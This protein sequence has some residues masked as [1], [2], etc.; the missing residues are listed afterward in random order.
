[1]IE[2]RKEILLHRIMCMSGGFMGGYAIINRLGH[3]A[4]AQTANIIE[5]IHNI[6]GRNLIEVV[7]R[8]LALLIYVVALSLGF[9]IG[10]KFGRK[11][12]RKYSFVVLLVGFI[13]L[14]FLPKNLDVALAVLPIFFMAATQ[15]S[16]FSEV[17][18]YNCSTI[19]CTNNI[20]QTVSGYTAYLMKRELKEKSRGSFYLIA[21]IFYYT[22]V[23]IAIYLS[24]KF[25][26]LSSIFGIA[27]VGIAI[28]VDRLYYTKEDALKP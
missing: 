21:I 4:L 11:W 10:E 8:V 16:A 13:G 1:M 2:E 19:F 3:F 9:Y 15:W 27:I 5:V 17:S 14:C 28:V 6:A 12:L 22:G 23:G 18:G 24:L 25:G 7:F 20:R 26:H